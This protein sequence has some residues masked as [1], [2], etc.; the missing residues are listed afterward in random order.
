MQSSAKH[1]A[2]QLEG[3][4]AGS[5]SLES[6]LARAT[7]FGAPMSSCF[8]GLQHFLVDS[9]LRQTDAGY[10]AMQES[11]MLKLIQALRSEAAPSNLERIHFLG[12]S[13]E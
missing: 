4:L 2:E 9:D 12:A 7:D 8:H 3:V 13:G 5:V 10:R 1:L 6:L 11:E